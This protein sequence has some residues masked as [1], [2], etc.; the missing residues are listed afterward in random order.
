MPSFTLFNSLALA[1]SRV[2]VGKLFTVRLPGELGKV[3]LV[4]KENGDWR[5]FADRCPHKMANFSQGGYLNGEGEVVC[6]LHHY[7]F[8][9]NTGQETSGQECP[10]LP[11]HNV[12]LTERGLVLTVE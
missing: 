6:P 10:L 9:L 11:T 5:A 4:R 12:E 8:D 7:V 2:P 1:E 3:C